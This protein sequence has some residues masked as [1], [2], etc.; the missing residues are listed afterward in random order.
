[1]KDYATPFDTLH[2]AS[3]LSHRSRLEKFRG[4]IRR[5]VEPDSHVVDLGTGTGVLAM[6]AA[7]AGARK[8]TAIDINGES[9]EYARRAAALNGLDRSVEFRMCHFKDYLPEEKADVVICEMLSSMMLIEQQIPAAAH[10]NHR[11]LKSGGEML[12]SSVTVFGVPVECEAG[13]NRFA[14]EDLR[15]P[16]VPQT[17]EKSQ[18]RD[19]SNLKTIAHF[20]LLKVT[21]T[22]RVDCSLSFEV[23]EEGTM[24]GLLGMFE[25]VLVPGT[26]LQMEDGWRELLIPLEKPLRVS[27]GD[28]IVLRLAYKPGVYDSLVLELAP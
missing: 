6:M 1:M 14:L 5:V 2:A 23:L 13:W 27:E 28:R 9:L 25:A 16:L 18:T 15:F 21:E 19:L 26:N 10:A 11:V 12:P 3:L 4:A 17:V 7:K 22:T 20:N 24:H 8:V